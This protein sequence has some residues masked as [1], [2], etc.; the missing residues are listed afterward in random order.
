MLMEALSVIA[1][2][3]SALI[4]L[5]IAVLVYRFTKQQATLQLTHDMR[6]AWMTLDQVAISSP[7]ATRIQS[8]IFFGEYKEGHSLER[9]HALMAMN[10]IVTAWQ[11]GKLGVANKET[12]AAAEA[13][14]QDMLRSP[15]VRNLIN[16]N[17]YEA[18]FRERAKELL[19][20][21]QRS[22]QI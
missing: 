8:E 7:E 9:W 11:L 19:R 5:V 15:I 18:S 13:I 3:I 6:N 10:P 12:V 16:E 21:S 4:S 2:A 17:I 22:E 20:S 1:N 14:L